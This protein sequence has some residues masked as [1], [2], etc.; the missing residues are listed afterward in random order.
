MAKAMARLLDDGDS[1]GE[2][3][4]AEVRLLHQGR[5]SSADLCSLGPITFDRVYEIAKERNRNK[6][7]A[8]NE[9]VER[10]TTRAQ[11]RSLKVQG[12]VVVFLTTRRRI[13]FSTRLPSSP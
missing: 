13:H 1:E 10:A 3:S 6:Q 5:I 7:A 12:V 8:A 11:A 4:D 9:K 2:E